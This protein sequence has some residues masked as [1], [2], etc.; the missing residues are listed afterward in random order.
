MEEAEAADARLKEG[1]SFTALAAERGLKE[2]D[3]DL[4]MATKVD[5]LDP[6]VADAAFAL[7]EGEV[8]APTV[9]NMLGLADRGRIFD[10]LENIFAGDTKA[11]IT[12]LASLHK[13]GAEP[14]QVL[15]DLAEAVHAAAR[16]KAV[17]A[18]AG[19]E[20]MSAE[21]RRRAEA[22]ASR[23]SVPLLARAWQMLLKGWE[24]TG[25]APNPRAAAE[26]VLIRLAHT[27]DLPAPDGRPPGR[28]LWRLRWAASLR[29]RASSRLRMSRVAPCRGWRR[30]LTRNAAARSGRHRASRSAQSEHCRW[31]R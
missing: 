5:I 18:D 16:C 14:E 20:V 4:G 23:L 7:K 24:E 26:M 17:G 31:P 11:A 8:S 1:L 9:R 30:G 25:K 27:A 10:L 21:E 2:Q 13:D 3:F 28:D 22:L 12:A 29:P 6:A 15:A 19:A